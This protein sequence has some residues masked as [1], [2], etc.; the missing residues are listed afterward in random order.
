MRKKLDAQPDDLGPESD[1]TAL[2]ILAKLERISSLA[3]QLSQ[4]ERWGRLTST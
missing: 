3:H 2:R 4:E 1:K